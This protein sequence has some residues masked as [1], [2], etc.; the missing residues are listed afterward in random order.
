MCYRL[1]PGFLFCTDMALVV[2]LASTPL[3]ATFTLLLLRHTS[4][5]L[6]LLGES[7]LKGRTALESPAL[8]SSSCC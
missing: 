7:G 5:A 3:I 1:A 4:L 2:V 8:R 6:Q